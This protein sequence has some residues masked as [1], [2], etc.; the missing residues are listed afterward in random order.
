MKEKYGIRKKLW[1]LH[2][3]QE[4]TSNNTEIFRELLANSTTNFFRF[5]I[6]IK[7]YCHFREFLANNTTYFSRVYIKQYNTDIF[8]EF[9]PN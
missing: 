5:N 9:L 4:L 6:I 8:R 7:R 3:F 1:I 2:T